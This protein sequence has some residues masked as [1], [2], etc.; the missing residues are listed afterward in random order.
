MLQNKILLV[1]IIGLA[2]CGSALTEPTKNKGT[3][4]PPVVSCESTVITVPIR[5]EAANQ[6]EYHTSLDLDRAC[7]VTKAII[8]GTGAQRV[9]A[10]SWERAD[11][12]DA[13]M[14]AA[15]QGVG[16]V[17]GIGWESKATD[18]LDSSRPDGGDGEYFVRT[19]PSQDGGIPCAQYGTVQIA[20]TIDGNAR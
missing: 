16:A 2:A 17:G 14:V 10:L 15:G 8:Q 11:D 6:C 13:S 18:S 9:N 4:N 1:S 12:L 3:G 7:R 20:L 19:D 5:N